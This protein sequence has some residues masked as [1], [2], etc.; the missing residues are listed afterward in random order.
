MC[1]RQLGLCLLHY[2]PPTFQVVLCWFSLCRWLV[3]SLFCS[4]GYWFCFIVDLL[5]AFVER[6]IS[7]RYGCQPFWP[8]NLSSFLPCAN[9]FGHT[10]KFVDK[11]MKFHY[12]KCVFFIK[13]LHGMAR[14]YLPG[15]HVYY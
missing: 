5:P 9:I 6:E 4:M 1:K 11:S 14:K 15:F 3:V 8:N 12:P 7:G 10:L 13:K 2:S